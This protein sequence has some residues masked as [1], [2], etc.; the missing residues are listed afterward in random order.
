MTAEPSVGARGAAGGSQLNRL[1]GVKVAAGG[2]AQSCRL[3][4]SE[5]PVQVELLEWSRAGV[6]AKLSVQ[7]QCGVLSSGRDL[8]PRTGGL[9][10]TP[11][12]T[13]DYGAQ[14]Q[15][16]DTA[17]Q[18]DVH[19]SILGALPIPPNTS[20]LSLDPDMAAIEAEHPIKK[21]RRDVLPGITR[22]SP[23][24]SYLGTWR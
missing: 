23:Q 13:V 8:K 7:R 9:V 19:Q 5:L 2:N 16:V 3:D 22:S 20:W 24:V 6:E 14:A 10:R 21:V 15:S 1:H 4:N 11:V 12:R 18:K 17:S